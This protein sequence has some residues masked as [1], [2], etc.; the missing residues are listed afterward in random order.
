MS[1][2]RLFFSAFLEAENDYT[3]DLHNLN[4]GVASNPFRELMVGAQFQAST[5]HCN[6]N[7]FSRPARRNCSGSYPVCEP[8]PGVATRARLPPRYIP[9]VD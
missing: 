6:V 2:L 7:L 9:A 5:A 3:I 1:Q 4:S 8:D